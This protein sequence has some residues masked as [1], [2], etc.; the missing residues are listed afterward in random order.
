M[1]ISVILQVVTSAGLIVALAAWDVSQT[2]KF[3]AIGV[4][5][6]G[7][8][9]ALVLEIY[10][11]LTERAAAYRTSGAING[12]MYRWI[13]KAGRVAIFSHNMSWVSEDVDFGALTGLYYAFARKDRPTIRELLLE[14]AEADDLIVCVPQHTDLTRELEDAGAEVIT[15]PELG[16]VPE[17]RF[18]IVRYGRA[19]SEVAIGRSDG[20]VHRIQTFPKGQ[21]PAFALAEDV[22]EFVKK[23]RAYLD[24]RA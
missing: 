10:E 3:L 23:Y 22:V 16:F 1:T 14:R 11:Y 17:G 2:W 20:S 24:G 12:F 18:T 21:H 7:A 15:Y 6:V 5:V 19:D 4:V 13:S 9:L 8:G